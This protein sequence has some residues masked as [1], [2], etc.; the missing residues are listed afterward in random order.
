M[1]NLKIEN[2]KNKWFLRVLIIGFWTKINKICKK[3][4]ESSNGVAQNIYRN[5]P[6]EI[7]G[8]TR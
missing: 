2:V 6:I 4:I 7:V 3:I 5:C 1:N 8:F